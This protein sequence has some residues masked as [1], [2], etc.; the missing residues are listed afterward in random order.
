MNGILNLMANKIEISHKTIIFT[1]GLLM[2][3]WLI[4][5]IRDILF[6]LFI[7]F[8]L[9][10]AVR[11]LVDYLSRFKIPQI[12]SIL[13]IYAT[14]FS[15]FGF[16]VAETLPS[17]ISQTVR[18]VNELP[19]FVARIMPYWDVDLNSITQQIAPLGENVLRFTVGIFSNII[20]TLTVLVFTFYFLLERRRIEFQLREIVGEQIANRIIR[21]ASQVEKRMG[22][23]VR[24]QMVLMLAVGL[25]T[26]A[27]LTLLHV[28]YALS[29]AL[30]AGILEIIPL[31]GPIVA[32][33]PAI[34]V[35][36][37][38][39]PFLALSV[40]AL[41]FII[42][43]LENHLLVPWVMKK[44]VGLSPLITIV[45]LMIGGKLAGVLG[46]ILAVPIVL[47]LEVIFS[48]ALNQT[49]S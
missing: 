14:V 35:A 40:L 44:S 3:L 7:S 41:Y 2:G 25:F 19:T 36:L 30:I 10:S 15:L 13:V 26:Y 17:F 45:A 39:S 9:M 11:P 47:V 38:T 1:I 6:L 33:I 37:G 46:A 27:G 43:Q 23:W 34:L 20:T 5:Q 4:F 22:A 32:A 28:D 21:I 16:I 49:K 12:F 31:I 8:I 18:L 29:L 42:Q 48:E 24:G